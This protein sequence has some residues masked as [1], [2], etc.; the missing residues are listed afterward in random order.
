[1]PAPSTG[2]VALLAAAVR[3]TH[4]DYFDNVRC[5]PHVSKSCC[6]V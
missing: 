5:Q 6:A 3:P 2:V 1:M 4:N